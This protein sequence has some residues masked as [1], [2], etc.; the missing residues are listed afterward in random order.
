MI[1]IVW[2][3]LSGILSLRTDVNV[4]TVNNRQKSQF[5]VGI[6]KETAKSCMIRSLIRNTVYGSKDPDPYQYVIDP[7]HCPTV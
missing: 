4:F 7:E 3:L 6:L 5:F 2:R 1:S